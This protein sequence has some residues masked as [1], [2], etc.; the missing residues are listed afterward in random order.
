VPLIDNGRETRRATEVH[1]PGR[2]AI[3]RHLIVRREGTGFES[4]YSFSHSGG[5]MLTVFSTREAARMYL[6]SDG[7]GDEW[8]VR[9][10]AG[11]E[12]V[13]LL[14]ALHDRLRG[15]LLDPPPGYR[16]DEQQVMWSLVDRDGF[17]EFLIGG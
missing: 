10:Y 15:V 11:G 2:P 4:P 3:V 1:P 8:Y 12:L 7:F 16:L 6:G 14:F 13:S 17:I 9:E 5:E